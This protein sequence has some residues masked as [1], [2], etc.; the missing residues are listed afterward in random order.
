MD[1]NTHAVGISFDFDLRD[2]RFIEGILDELRILKSSTRRSPTFFVL[3]V[4]SGVPVL[5]YADAKTMRIN[6]LPHCTT[7]CLFSLLRAKVMWEDRFSSLSALP[8]ALA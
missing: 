2:A 1:E 3:G 7:S 5:D 4:P 8:R 6:F